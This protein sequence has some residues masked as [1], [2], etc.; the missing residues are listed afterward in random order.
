[1]LWGYQEA[2]HMHMVLNNQRLTHR[3]LVLANA[4]TTR[5]ELLLQDRLRACKFYYVAS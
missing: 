4:V 5:F 2:V 1:M 3:S